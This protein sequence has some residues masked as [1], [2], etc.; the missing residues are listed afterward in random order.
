MEVEGR[1][2]SLTPNWSGI[3]SYVFSLYMWRKLKNE[4]SQKAK[5]Q[6]IS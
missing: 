2:V 4:Q 3:T 6:S 1:E 5:M